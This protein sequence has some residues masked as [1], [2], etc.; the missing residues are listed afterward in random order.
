MFST[1]CRLQFLI[2]FIGM[3][4]LLGCKTD[5][6][7][8]RSKNITAYVNP[9]IGTGG[10]GHTYPGATLPFGMVQLSPDTRLEG[11]D[12]CSGYHYSDSII[13]G[14]SHTHL[15]GTGVS[16]YGDVLL[17]PTSG[18]LYFDNGYKGDVDAG[19][20]SRFSHKQETASP[21]FYSVNLKDYDIDVALSVSPR[22][23]FH[24]YTFNKGGVSHVI[25]DL[26]HRD[27]LLDYDIEVVDAITIQGKRIS[28][29]WANEQHVYFYMQFS[30]P[31]LEAIFPKN[32]GI[33]SKKKAA[34]SFDTEPGEKLYVKVGLSA[35]SEIG[36]KSNL[37]AELAGWNFE[38]IKQEAQH[39][40]EK[41]LGKIQI[42][43]GTVNQKTIFYTALYHSLLSPNLYQDVDG[44]YR[45]MDLQVHQTKAHTNYSVFSLWDTFRATH[46]L[47][48]IVEQNRTNDFI[49]TFIDQYD[50]GGLLP[51]W[52]LAA[53]YTGCMIGYHSIPVITDAYVKGIRGYDA[54]KVFK[55]MQHSAN[56]DHLGLKSYKSLG[57]IP[58]DQEAESVSKTL[59]YAYDDWCISKMAR[60]LNEQEDASYFLERAQY[61]KNI[62]DPQNGF[63]RAKVNGSWFGPFNPSEVNFNYTEANAWQ[64]SLFVPQDIEGLIS[65]YG[66]PEHFEQQLDNLF[67]ASKDLTGRAQVD[68][69]GLIGQYAHGNEPSH[70]MAYLYNFIGKPYK[71]QFRIRQIL[72]SLYKNAPN[73]LS[74]NED[75]GQM[76]SWYVLSAM[77]FYPVTPGLPYYTIGAPL[78]EEVAIHLENGNT[79]KIISEN[80]SS[81]NFYVQDVTLNGQPYKNS[82]LNHDIIMN[83]GSLSFVM[84]DAPN[85][86]AFSNK[87]TASIKASLITPVPYFE[88]DSRTFSDSQE[89]V[90]RGLEH[91]DELFYSVDNNNFKR[92][93]SPII[94]NRTTNFKAYAL[95]N[96]KKSHEVQAAYFKIDASRKIELKTTYANQYAAGGNNA[97]VDY[98]RGGDNFRTGSWQGYEGQDFNAIVD[99]GSI[100]SFST[101]G[102]GFLQDVKSWIYFP[103]F[104]WFEGSEDGKVYKNLGVVT[105]SFSDQ[106]EASK[107]YNFE[108]KK[109]MNLRYIRIKA[110]S[111][112]VNPQWHPGA[113]KPTWLFA[114]EIYTK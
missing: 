23:G 20:G 14:F 101:L 40:W 54:Q 95:R 83:G 94:I 112:G 49:N 102:I 38:A 58:A 77:G 34:L 7:S 88:S 90:I 111:Y 75:C 68:I 81:K 76:S 74:G 17:M 21:G 87:P 12:G 67:N 46:P 56:Q 89:V 4:F 78:F 55:A 108:I 45:G 29:A 50:K 36:A 48:T 93:T 66:G 16:D 44:K 26:T 72:E 37:Q 105:H 39:K 107:T 80:N 70:H 97:L 106:I 28:R 57:Y 33:N 22:T 10:H 91:K 71:T 18:E 79:F 110:E 51:I 73:G 41:Q 84:G 82:Y 92:Y 64:Y 113:G 96:G 35:V 11:W 69:T 30:K 42:K 5:K 59:E 25:L 31:F 99:L 98:M 109:K 43:G 103:K 15:S 114:D 60:L 2:V 104:V 47:Y 24:E 3:F 6:F 1:N 61:Y 62:F 13:Y 8:T 52:E 53:N 32:E 100:K 85:S 19:Y 27:A 86:N 9:F 65:L 63:M